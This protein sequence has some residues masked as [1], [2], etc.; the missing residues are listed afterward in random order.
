M[1][2]KKILP[3]ILL[4]CLFQTACKNTGSDNK[5]KELPK[6]LQG[7]WYK[8]YVGTIAGQPVIVNLHHYSGNTVGCYNY[9]HKSVIIDLTE[10]E[11][12]PD[13][14]SIHFMEFVRTSRA[15]DEE[16]Y[17]PD[18]WAINI[19]DKEIKGNWISGDSTK[20]YPIELKEDYTEDS[21]PLSIMVHADSASLR[22][23]VTS[24][25]AVSAY[26][27]LQPSAQ[28][29]KDDA[30]FFRTTILQFLG[31]DTL[32][33]DNLADYIKK[34]DKKYFENYKELLKDITIDKENNEEWQ[35]NFE[36]IRSMWVLYNEGGMLCLELHEYD[37]SGGGSGHGNSWQN[38]VCI[39]MHQKRVWRL[40]D[41]IRVD[42]AD[43]LPLLDHEIR[44][45][46][47]LGPKDTL[48]NVLAVDKVPLSQKV[49][50]TDKGITFCYDPMEIGTEPD[51]EISLFIPYD[52]LKG[53]LK[54]DFKKRMNL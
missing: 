25:L 3:Y 9:A 38:Y 37:Y 1:S 47:K 44:K 14:Y 29:K 11:D 50:I 35:Y 52:R 42:A 28:M 10:S 45:I 21:Y 43:L 36:H 34:E 8:R 53:M 19:D 13:N 15:A 26:E 7:E 46:Y 33:A 6:T 32:G 22:K 12:K 18:R 51:G 54:D 30:V 5:D 49:F 41:I 24:T 39:D 4:I 23:G 27:L 2:V 48:S 16:N 20:T 17:K 40:E 31:A